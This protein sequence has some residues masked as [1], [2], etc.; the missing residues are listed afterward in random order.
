MMSK[1]S[2]DSSVITET[3]PSAIITTEAMNDATTVRPDNEDEH[4]NDDEVDNNMSN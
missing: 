1:E 4:E 2:N 3:P